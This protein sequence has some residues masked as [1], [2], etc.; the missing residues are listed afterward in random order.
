[1]GASKLTKRRDRRKAKATG[2]KRMGRGKMGGGAAVHGGGIGSVGHVL[3]RPGKPIREG[4]S[5]VGPNVTVGTSATTEPLGNV[6]RGTIRLRAD[7]G[8]TTP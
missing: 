1:M 6:A 3:T 4:P 2:W 7:D 5:F 8:S